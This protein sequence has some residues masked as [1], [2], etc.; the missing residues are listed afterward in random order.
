MKIGA[1]IFSS[2]LCNRLFKM[3]KKYGV[4]YQFG[5]SPGVECQDGT[6]IIKKILHLRHNHNLHICVAFAGLAKVFDTMN[7]KM[8]LKI[9]TQHGV[10]LKLCSAIGRMYTNL[11]VVLKIDKIEESMP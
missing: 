8:M 1:K 6:F 9:L 11:R 5:S 3:I 7:H 4:K 2:I 10:P